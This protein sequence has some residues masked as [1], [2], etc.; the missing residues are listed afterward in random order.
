MQPTRN[1]VFISCWPPMAR[2]AD[3]QCSASVRAHGAKLKSRRDDMTIA[4]GKRSA[5]RGWGHKMICSLFSNLVCPASF[6]GKLDWKTERLGVGGVLP[7]AAIASRSCP[8]LPSCRPDGTPE[9]RTNRASQRR[10]SGSRRGGRQRP[11]RGCA[12]RYTE[13]RQRGL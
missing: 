1:S 3:G 2:A 11:R 4:P 13:G 10:D 9:G 12:L 8:G 5:A 6:R 7:R